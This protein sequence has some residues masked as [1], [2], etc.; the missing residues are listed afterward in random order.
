MNSLT[1]DY[2]GNYI[3]LADPNP[4]H[5]NP[6]MLSSCDHYSKKEDLKICEDE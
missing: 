5:V 4:Y 2:I 3:F 6:V 1:N